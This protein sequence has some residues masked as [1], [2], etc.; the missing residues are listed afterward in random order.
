MKSYTVWRTDSRE[1]KVG[2]IMLSRGD[3]LATFVDPTLIAAEKYIRK[4][5]GEFDRIRR[6]SLYTWR[7]EEWAR[8]SWRLTS[9]KTKF[10]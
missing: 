9:E 3:S 5:G 7:D 1:L 6:E 10:F 4:M 2:E 8:F